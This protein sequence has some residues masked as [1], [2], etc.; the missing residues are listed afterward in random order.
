[1]NKDELKG[2]AEN[3]KGRVKE[4][5]GSLTGD[6]SKQGEGFIERVK[7]TVREKLGK[8]KD[9]TSHQASDETL[10]E[11]SPE[12]SPETSTETSSGTSGEEPSIRKDRS[13]S[14]EEDED[15]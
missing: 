8:A 14:R 4:A 5:F 6:K 12:G 13:V 15:E 3:L 1:M 7:G 2:R 11:T 10:H 9:E